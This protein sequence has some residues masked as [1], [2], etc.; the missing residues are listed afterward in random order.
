MTKKTLES[1]LKSLSEADKANLL[2][3]L[4]G[5]AKPK[6]AKAEAKVEYEYRK[7]A[8][9][10]EVRVKG[11]GEFQTRE[12]VCNE[13][14]KPSLNNRIFAPPAD[15]GILISRKGLYLPKS[16]VKIVNPS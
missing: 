3:S 1:I 5:E 6:T 16:N 4:V 7:V 11:K 8:I 2:T 13:L 15:S 12:I 10:A 9:T 14:G